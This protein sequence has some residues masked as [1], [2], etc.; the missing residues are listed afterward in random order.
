MSGTNYFR[1]M[2]LWMAIC[3][4]AMLL[5]YFTMSEKSFI[6][7]CHMI[8]AANYFLVSIALLVLGIKLLRISHR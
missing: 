1:L 5:C 2:W 6:A 7:A 8:K 3:V 4:A